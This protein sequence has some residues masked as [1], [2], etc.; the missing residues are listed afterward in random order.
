MEQLQGCAVH[1][2]QGRM[3]GGKEG[4]YGM[5]Y[6]RPLLRKYQLV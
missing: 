5:K 3:M 1:H 6:T 2:K 4:K